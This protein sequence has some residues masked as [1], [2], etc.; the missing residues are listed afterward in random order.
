M[1]KTTNLIKAFL[2]M[3]LAILKFILCFLNFITVDWKTEEINAWIE[4]IESMTA[5]KK[6]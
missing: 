4:K 2:N 5:I 3:P 6:Y 1:N